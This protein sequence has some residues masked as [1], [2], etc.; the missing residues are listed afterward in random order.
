MVV[1]RKYKFYTHIF[2][3]FLSNLFLYNFMLDYVT[4]FVKT[5][6]KDNAHLCFYLMKSYVWN[7]DLNTF[8]TLN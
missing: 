5:A 4:N 8:N 3:Y 6:H 7:K 1:C 2:T